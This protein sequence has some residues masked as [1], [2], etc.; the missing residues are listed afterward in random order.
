MLYLNIRF[1]FGILVYLL[2]RANFTFFPFFNFGT[3]SSALHLE[4]QF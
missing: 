3:F 4:A 2:L 1:L